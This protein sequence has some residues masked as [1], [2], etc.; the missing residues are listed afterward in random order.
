VAE[1]AVWSSA[2]VLLE[3]EE[4]CCVE[5]AGASVETGVGPFVQ[6]RLD[7]ALGFAVGAGPAGFDVEAAES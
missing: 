2:V 6:E 4:E 3:V 7:D 5:F 1:A